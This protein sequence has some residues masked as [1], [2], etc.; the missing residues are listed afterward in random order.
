MWNSCRVNGK[1]RRNLR[2]KQNLDMSTHSEVISVRDRSE[3][4]AEPCIYIIDTLLSGPYILIP[5]WSQ[6]WLS[7]NFSGRGCHSFDCL[8]FLMATLN[9]YSRMFGC[10]NAHVYLPVREPR[11]TTFNAERTRHDSVTVAMSVAAA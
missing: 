5:H 2:H 8:Y 10:L 4:L 6:V 9:A 3:Y 7:A 1:T 11:G